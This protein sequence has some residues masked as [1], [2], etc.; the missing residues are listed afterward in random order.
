MA[1][2]VRQIERTTQPQDGAVFRA[3]LFGGL[4]ELILHAP[5]G[6]AN[7]GSGS[8]TLT[9][10][11]PLAPG[12]TGR[13]YTFNGSSDRILTGVLGPATSSTPQAT[14]ILSFTP[15]AAPSGSTYSSPFF[16]AKWH[17]SWDHGSSAYQGVWSFN[18]NAG[19]VNVNLL[20]TTA[21]RPTTVVVTW[22]GAT[23]YVYQDG[24]LCGTATLT[25]NAYGDGD[26]FDLGERGNASGYWW[27]GGIDLAI[28]HRGNIAL[29]LAK[30]IS[31]QPSLLWEPE[32]IV[33]KTG[34]AAVPSGVGSA[35]LQRLSASG[36][37][38]HGVSGSASA[39][40]RPLS[41]SGS[42]VRGQTGAAAATL[43]ALSASG[44]GTHGYACA[45]LATLRP[46]NVTASGDHGITGA[47]SAT[48]RAISAAAA[49]DFTFVGDVEGIGAA[50]LRALTARG[51]GEHDPGTTDAGGYA[52]PFPAPPWQ[53]ISRATADDRDLLELLPIVIGVMNHA[54]R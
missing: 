41:A 46:I 13:E 45:G 54:G 51:A 25:G 20:T 26:A 39:T 32:Q 9:G 53:G 31:G 6:V 47:V 49:G 15:S 27:P 35:T 11:P 7:I 40:L 36:A 12:R 10:A 14:A 8:Q 5:A 23:Q 38:Q 48:L 18:D 37:V 28:F 1:V 50:T 4:P 16:T 17:L 3:D 22:E 24:V 19:W 30:R 52:R 21:G 33:V 29:D 2:R 44:V 43:R 34:A 42:G